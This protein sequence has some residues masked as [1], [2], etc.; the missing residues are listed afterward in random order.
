[1]PDSSILVN[2][3][4][5]QADTST[6]AV[7]QYEKCC[8]LPVY[9]NHLHIDSGKNICILCEEHEHWSERDMKLSRF[10]L[11]E[12]PYCLHH[13]RNRVKCTGEITLN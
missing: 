12:S 4:P 6:F 1:M 9:A 8:Y 5:S 7:L 11:L 2:S 13:H 3:I 10:F